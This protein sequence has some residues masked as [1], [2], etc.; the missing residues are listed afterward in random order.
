M[1]DNLTLKNYK[2]SDGQT[3]KQSSNKKDVLVFF[4]YCGFTYVYSTDDRGQCY[5]TPYFRIADIFSIFPY[6]ILRSYKDPF[7]ILREYG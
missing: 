1:T 4:T 3:L 7:S 5:K 6:L 2:K